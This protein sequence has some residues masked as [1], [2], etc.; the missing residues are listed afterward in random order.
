MRVGKLRRNVLLQFLLDLRDLQLRGNVSLHRTQTFLHV[1][2]LQDGL[3]LGKIDIE[4]RREKID[5]LLRGL[6]AA[7]DRARSFRR[8]RSQI[9]Q[10]RG[11][12]AQIPELG[13]ELLGLRRRNGIEQLHLGPHIWIGRNN[14]AQRKPAQPLHEHDDVVV[15]LPQKFENDRG[16]AD[17]IQVLRRR[18]FLV[19]I[20][21][22]DQPDDFA[23]RQSFV[24]QLDR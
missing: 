16:R 18:I 12:I 6:D 4:I 10:A 3:L 22:R 2:F 20:A 1:E 7:N 17:F 21:L 8:F 13:F 15:R 23:L 14:F 24:E 5:Q 19:R 11:G 9:E